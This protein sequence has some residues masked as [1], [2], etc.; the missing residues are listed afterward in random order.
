[1]HH[2]RDRE[3]PP[4]TLLTR[5]VKGVAVLEQRKLP[6]TFF[7]TEGVREVGLVH[8]WPTKSRRFYVCM[9]V[10]IDTMRGKSVST[11]N[12]CAVSMHLNPSQRHS[13]MLLQT[14]TRRTT[15]SLPTDRH[16]ASSKD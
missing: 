3:L 11:L 4:F 8:G 16:G 9:C 13:K 7:K 2:G 6:Q 10:V 12:A 15:V 1:M 14:G 5:L